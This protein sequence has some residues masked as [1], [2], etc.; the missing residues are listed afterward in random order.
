[1]KRLSLQVGGLLIPIGSVM[2]MVL[3]HWLFL[4]VVE[5]L[6]IDLILDPITVQFQPMTTV[7]SVGAVISMEW[8]KLFWEKESSRT[9]STCYF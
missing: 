6:L 7:F 4:V 2:P 1:M 3:Y 9:F 5:C 8:E